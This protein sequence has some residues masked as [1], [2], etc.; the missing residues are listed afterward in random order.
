MRLPNG[1]RER[2]SAGT[3]CVAA[4]CRRASRLSAPRARVVACAGARAGA[5]RARRGGQHGRANPRRERGRDQ[6]LDEA[7]LAREAARGS[8]LVADG[9][10][11]LPTRKQN[12]RKQTT[13]VSAFLPPRDTLF[14]VAPPAP[15]PAPRD[16]CRHPLSLAPPLL[17]YATRDSQL[18]LLTST[19]RA[20]NPGTEQPPPTSTTHRASR[21]RV[22][23][24]RHSLSAP[25]TAAATLR[26]STPRHTT[27]AQTNK[28]WVRSPFRR[29]SSPPIPAH[30][31]RAKKTYRH[32]GQTG[33][34]QPRQGRPSRARRTSSRRP[35]R[36]SARR[37]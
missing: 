27:H 13:R 25:T 16:A 14:A 37:R 29:A 8:A 22:Y 9:R 30:C 28:P 7:Q 31:A 24:S 3:N 26:S 20:A 35:R 12:R 21:A 32:P 5:I 17:L 10:A 1:E 33:H 23:T 19:S 15:A 2:D 36:L 18:A 4:F 34:P 6:R 11:F